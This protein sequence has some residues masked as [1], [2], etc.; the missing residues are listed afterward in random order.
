MV[1]FEYLCICQVLGE[2]LRR[3]LYQATVSKCPDKPLWGK[4]P[5]NVSL[6]LFCVGNLLLGMRPDLK[7]GFLNLVSLCEDKNPNLSF[8]SCLS[9]EDNFWVRDGS[10]CPLPLSALRPHQAQT[11][12]CLHVSLCSF[13]C[14]SVLLCLKG[15]AS[16]VFSIPLWLLEFFHFLFNRFS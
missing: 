5:P 1:G 14:G 4:E 6:S 8:L 15:R 9:T 16:L 13:M 11:Y 3:Q 10:S 2:P 12:A 7:S